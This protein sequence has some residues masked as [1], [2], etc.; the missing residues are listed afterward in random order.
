MQ[1]DI[2][3]LLVFLI[4]AIGVLVWL[5][6][7]Q[8]NPIPN[9]GELNLNAQ[10]FTVNPNNLVNKLNSNNVKLTSQYVDS[11]LKGSE[12]NNLST[13][14]RTVCGTV[15]IFERTVIVSPIGKSAF[16]FSNNPILL[17]LQIYKI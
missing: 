5:Q 4:I 17:F 2:R 1:K 10:H 16:N 15:D 3:F 12:T 11:V 7:N 9:S 14:S 6:S 8:T 13:K